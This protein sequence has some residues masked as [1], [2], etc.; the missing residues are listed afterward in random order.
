M[1][2]TRTQVAV[3]GAGPAGLILAEATLDVGGGESG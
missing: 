3:V 2:R 1:T